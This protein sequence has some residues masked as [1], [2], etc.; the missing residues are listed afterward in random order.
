MRRPP[1]AKLGAS[2]VARRASP[3]LL[4]M[5]P[6]GSCLLGVCLLGACLLAA[7]T[8]AQASPT[9]RLVAK[10]P[11]RPPPPPPP[12]RPPPW[13][14]SEPAV[15]EAPSRDPLEQRIA[16]VLRAARAGGQQAVKLAE[17]LT[18]S[19]LPPDERLIAVRAIADNPSPK[20]RRAL[21]KTVS[22]SAVS[23]DQSELAALARRTAAM[24][25]AA[26]GQP[27]AL[28]ALGM[29]LRQEGLA[30]EAARGA[31]LAHPPADLQLI[32][33]GGG[34]VSSHYVGL[35]SDLGDQRAFHPLREVVRRDAGELG[36]AAAL[37]LTRLGAFETEALAKTWLVD[38]LTAASAAER[39]RHL[40]SARILT[41]A[42]SAKVPRIVLQ[43]LESDDWAVGVELA[44]SAPHPALVPALLAL[45]ERLHGERRLELFAALGAAGGEQ[46]TSRLVEALASED[47]APAALALARSPGAEAALTAALGEP[48]RAHAASR[49]LALRSVAWRRVSGRAERTWREQLRSKEPAT[50]AAGAFGLALTSD[51]HG[52]ALILRDDP[53]VAIAAARTALGRPTLLLACAERL[54]EERDPRVA[55]AMAI[56][57]TSPAAAERVPTEALLRLVHQGGAARYLA[58]YAL[59]QRDAPA[60][61][62]EI[63]RWLAAGDP[64]LR[65][66]AALGLGLAAHPSAVGRL[67]RA[68]RFESDPHV[69]HALVLAM[70]SRP[71]PTR[72]RLLQTTA[73]LDP[74][75]EVYRAA[76]LLAKQPGAPRTAGQATTWLELQ[77][78]LGSLAVLTRTTPA[79]P[80]VPDP[81]G[82]CPVAGL[83]E[84]ELEVI[85]VPDEPG[86]KPAP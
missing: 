45:L 77:G 31:L 19:T 37:A 67:E 60:L 36:A 30:G 1:A 27:D 43:L 48:T 75:A 41:L 15:I 35:L 50:R 24:A 26:S 32:T 42:R 20:V 58:V 13:S 66:S 10:S 18:S 57:L 64:E 86:Q 84:G 85:A 52:R 5:S 34:R 28:R 51:D 6:L 11:V 21:L 40:T 69:R 2:C 14:A 38:D 29:L 63:E 59:S 8:T 33:R 23:E 78:G 17:Q 62:P 4:G 47:Q 22:G 56:S 83:P 7:P 73:T 68:Y 74:D 12:F 65:R 79:L 71:E 3:S 25:L 55:T 61:R 53:A 44:R 70:G 80:F 9:P 39:A 82:H 76:R 54:A 72:R 49:A 16:K 81:D 46:A